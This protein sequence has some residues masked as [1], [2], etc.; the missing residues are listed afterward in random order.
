MNTWKRFS[1]CGLIVLIVSFVFFSCA[2]TPRQQPITQESPESKP[3]ELD[4]VLILLDKL[5]EE[6]YVEQSIGKTLQEGISKLSSQIVQTLVAEKRNRVAVMPFT[7]LEK[8]QTRLGLYLA[9]KLT[10]ELFT[11]DRKFDVVD[12]FHMEEVLEE[13]KIGQTGLQDSETIQQVGK[14]LG[15]DA[16]VTGTITDLEDE[17]DVNIRMLATERAN[18]IAVASTLFDKD[19]TIKKLLDDISVT[20]QYDKELKGSIEEPRKHENKEKSNKVG[21]EIILFDDFSDGIAKDWEFLSGSWIESDNIMCQTETIDKMSQARIGKIQWRNYIVEAKIMFYDERS[22]SYGGIDFRCTKSSF[23][24]FSLWRNRQIAEIRRNHQN[25]L[26]K[27]ANIGSYRWYVLK[28]EVRGNSVKCYLDGRLILT[29]EDLK[30]FAGN[31]G[32]VTYGDK[33]CF[34]YIKVL[35]IGE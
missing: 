26:K 31:V 11:S 20:Q 23:Y 15:A 7:T 6:K 4:S 12:R 5:K 16:I 10:N 33:I 25:I 17:V 21:S 29:F 14:V 8:Q 34:D 28:A 2:S 3:E 35:R 9:D 18:V 22:S 24:T 27:S 1:F 13:M 32:L 30:N 19:D